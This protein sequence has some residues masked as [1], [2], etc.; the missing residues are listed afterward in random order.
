MKFTII[1][2]NISWRK[3]LIADWGF[4][5]LVEIDGRKILFDTGAKG[6]VLIHNMKA[7][8]IDPSAIDIVFISHPHWD[9]VGG[10][11]TVLVNADCVVYV[12]DGFPSSETSKRFVRVKDTTRIERHLFSTGELGRFEQALVIEDGPE[13]VLLVGCSH[14]GLSNM[15]EAASRT[16]E[17]TAII[18]G[19]HGF[20]QFD[21]IEGLHLICPTH[22][23]RHIK[24][25]QSRYPDKYIKGGVGTVV[26]IR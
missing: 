9:H 14:P 15:L 10:L 1:Y 21:L 20:D 6:P 8:D 11:E 26:T 19:L 22:C 13:K 24:Q 7:L 5:C 16:G 17:V 4:A 12:P 18:G 23:T 2:D 3:D 25:I